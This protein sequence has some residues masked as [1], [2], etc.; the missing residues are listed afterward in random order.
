MT[1]RTLPIHLTI[2]ASLACALLTPA[3]GLAK[4]KDVSEPRDTKVGLGLALGS[5]GSAMDI[6]VD[7]GQFRLEPLL[8]ATSLRM[9]IQ[10][11]SGWRVEPELGFT[12]LDASGSE[13]SD[14]KLACGLS[15]SWGLGDKGL[16]YAGGRIG[17]FGMGYDRTYV[18]LML[19]VGLG[20]E[21]W[22]SSYFTLGGEAQFNLVKYGEDL[23][24]FSLTSNAVLVARF[25]FN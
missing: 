12:I 21:Y 23:D 19:G 7:G 14:W 4:K 24:G 1:T 25:F 2:C 17:L 10:T 20:G 18:D 3:D 5:S 22:V 13:Y 8:S 15:P 16:A 11:S 9:P 6:F